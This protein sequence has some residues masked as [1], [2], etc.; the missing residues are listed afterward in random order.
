M[1]LSAAKRFIAGSPLR[2]PDTS[3]TRTPTQVL[4]YMVSWMLAGA[5]SRTIPFGVALTTMCRTERRINVN[6]EFAWQY[7]DWLTHFR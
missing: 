5:D 3:R 7:R 2:I 4:T 1:D 6:F